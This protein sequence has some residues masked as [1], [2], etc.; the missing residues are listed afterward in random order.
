MCYLKTL[1]DVI[2]IIA[3]IIFLSGIVVH[4]L[5]WFDVIHLD[6]DTFALY[7][8]W[9]VASL[10]IGLVAGLWERTKDPTGM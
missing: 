1:F 7:M 8:S 2:L 5:I 9:W 4:P 6:E 10:V 3:T